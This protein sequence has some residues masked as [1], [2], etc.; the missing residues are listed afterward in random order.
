MIP[1][2]RLIARLPLSWLHCA[3]SALGWLIYWTS[4]TFAARL[5]DNLFASG[6]CA[7]A[8]ACAALLRQAVAETGKGAVE[9]VRQAK[10]KGLPT[11]YLD[12]KQDIESAVEYAFKKN[13][14]KPIILIGS[15]YSASLALL[16]AKDSDKVKAV[17]VFSP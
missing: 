3:G 16:I 5:R 7:D 1:L 15:S 11:G 4:P 8:V 6:V 9:L 12:A 17:A 14:N 13:H 10:K 2:L